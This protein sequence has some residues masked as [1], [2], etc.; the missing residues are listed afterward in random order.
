MSGDRKLKIAI[1]GSGISGLSAAWLLN[2]GHDI[3]VFEK[4][5][6]LGGHSN[7]VDAL[8]D[9]PQGRLS[10]PVD[11]GFIVYNER[12][13]PNLTALFEHLDIAT[14][15]SVMSF[16]ASMNAGGF[17]YSGAGLTGL[18]AQ[19]R[20]LVRPRFW[21]MVLDILRFY[22]ECVRDAGLPENAE[23]TLGDYLNKHGYSDGFLRDHIYPMASSI[24]SATFEEIREYPLTAF[25]RFFSNHGLLETKQD[26]RPKWRTVSGGSKSYV[27]RIAADFSDNILLNTS[28]VGVT[29]SPEGVSIFTEDGETHSFDHVVFASHSNQALAML[30]DPTSDERTLLSSIR[31][32]YNRA[33]LHTDE[34]M[35]PRRR[36]AWA[37][38]NYISAGKEDQSQLVCLSYWMNLLQNI[39]RDYPVFVTLNPHRD[40]DPAKTIRSFDYEHPIFDQKALD[41]QKQLWALQGSNR[42]WYCGAYFGYGFHEDGL[43]SGLAV[44]EQLGGL[45]RPWTVDNESG[46]ICMAGLVDTP[47]TVQEAA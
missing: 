32:E 30:N 46:R 1:I 21:S 38:W 6:R 26:R 15:E 27:D 39:D 29:R 12:T 19:K 3:T 44:A 45:K 8:I 24:W 2:Q 14:E 47:S 4:D 17:E 43:Q 7:T 35:M 37:S 10:I 34:S 31:Y 40:P 33:V 25:V 41:A 42:T 18:L 22:R 5:G 20:N 28:V 16:S 13:Y 11:T 23:L 36:R 9:G